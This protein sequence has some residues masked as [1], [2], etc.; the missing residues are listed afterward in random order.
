M[1]RSPRALALGAGLVALALVPAAAAT[2]NQPFYLDLVRRIMIFAIA[3]LSL[4]LILGYGGMVSFGH[5]AYLGI[6]AYAVGVLAHHGVHDGFVQWGLA[7]AASALVA[8]GIGAVSIRTSGVYFIMITL[9]F[10]Q[11]LYYLGISIEEYGGDDG[12]RLA[13]RS[14][15]RLIDLRDGVTFYYVVLAILLLCLLLGHRLVNARFGMVIRSVKSNEARARAIGFS[16]YRYK[17]VAFVVAGAMCGVA[18]AL[19]VNHTE[20]LTP[21]FMHWTRSG[22]IMFMVILGGMGTLTGP[23]LGAVVLLLLE[24]VL[25]AWTVHWQIVLG[26]FLVLVVLFA[27][28]GLAGLLPRAAAPHG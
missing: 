16:P 24:D 2:L 20:Y 10:T 27:R 26:P 23:V 21:E 22:E 8:L 6:G 5:A 13:A 7:V 4:D 28:R 19:L 25:S 14:Q 17:L 3:A 15:F 9:A 12:M 1:T 11:M 18:G